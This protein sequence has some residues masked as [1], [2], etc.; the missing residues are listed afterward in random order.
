MSLRHPKSPIGPLILL[1][2]LAAAGCGDRHTLRPTAPTGPAEVDGTATPAEEV[3]QLAVERGIG[4][5]PAPPP[6]R[7]ALVRL[8]RALMF[9]PILSGNR[10]I[11][12]MTCH[13]PRFAM[14]D[15][16][17]LA[18]GQGATGIG[19]ERVH[20]D[21]RYIFRNAPPLF[22]LHALSSFLW[23]GRV[24]ADA[25]G[26]VHI[27]NGPRLSDDMSRVLEFGPLSAVGLLPVLSRAE[28]RAS[29]GN[30]LAAIPDSQSG[31]VW[32][33]L[34]RRLGAVP[35]Y[36]ELFEAAYP[37]TP[38]ERMN[39]AYASNA[40][41]GFMVARLAFNRLSLGPV[42]RRRGRCARPPTT[43]G[44]PHFHADPLLHLPQRTGIHR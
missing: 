9:D 8:G 44:R 39:F 12:C 2:A 26:H 6:V 32:R 29:A 34:M 5:L 16:R 30:E 33:A 42:P 17:H 35:E 1:V 10:D 38:F 41:A 25:A 19:P 13:A 23:D 40:M 11:A 4:P 36:R 3:R 24:E 22:N 15:A 7:P 43:G 28:M 14:G 27:L 21:G 18:I 37:G 31:R 20:P